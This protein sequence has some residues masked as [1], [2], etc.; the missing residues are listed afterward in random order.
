I[1]LRDELL[2][3]DGVSDITYLGERDY[4]IRAWLDPQKMASY[5]LS[6]GDVAKAIEAQNVEPAAGR[7]AQAPGPA[8]RSFQI[9]IGALGR[10]GEPEQFGDII[11]KVGGGRPATGGVVRVAPSLDSTGAPA[12]G[13]GN[14]LPAS[15]TSG[16]QTTASSS[17]TAQ[18]TTGG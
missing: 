15:G 11:V 5:S 9:P 3:V 8:N 4:S 1:N 13:A 7:L 16:G 10:L 6:A 2:R 17:T 18:S 12:P 14:P